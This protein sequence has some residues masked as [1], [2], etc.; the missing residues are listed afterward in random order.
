MFVSFLTAGKDLLLVSWRAA[1]EDVED[2][3]PSSHHFQ[4]GRCPDTHPETRRSENIP[5]RRN[6]RNELQL[7]LLFQP[8][9]CRRSEKSSDCCWFSPQLL[10]FTCQSVWEQDTE[11]RR[12]DER[13]SVNTVLIQSIY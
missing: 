1:D 12:V 5:Q 6:G 11:P 9:S 13:L 8:T 3:H 4:V 7:L 2:A 10:R